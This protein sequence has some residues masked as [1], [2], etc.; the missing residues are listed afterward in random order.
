MDPRYS[1]ER[2]VSPVRTSLPHRGLP[3]AAERTPTKGPDPCANLRAARYFCRN[4]SV[5]LVRSDA[6][7]AGGFELALQNEENPSGL[8]KPCLASSLSHP[9]AERGLCA[10][11]APHAPPSPGR[12][13]AARGRVLRWQE[14]TGASADL[15]S[16]G[17]D[18]LPWVTSQRP[19]VGP[20]SVFISRLQNSSRDPNSN[21]GGKHPRVGRSCWRGGW[22]QG[23]A[24]RVQLSHSRVKQLRNGSGGDPR[25]PS[26]KAAPALLPGGIPKVSP[27]ARTPPQG[28]TC[29]CQLVGEA[30]APISST[31]GISSPGAGLGQESDPAWPGG[32][33]SWCHRAVAAGPVWDRCMPGER[34]E[35]KT[36]KT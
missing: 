31:K 15:P 8:W 22:E 14:D 35:N 33:L 11:G 23:W 20:A 27:A 29:V 5:R 30:P 28:F 26:G 7:P 2:G 18:H 19:A 1:R 25:T 24:C 3:A 32:W 16:D 4:A 9:G 13:A 21:S 10:V 36:A 6:K 17:G 34:T 12:A